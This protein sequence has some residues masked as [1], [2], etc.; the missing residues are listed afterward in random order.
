MDF[1]NLRIKDINCALKYIPQTKE[2]TS[3]NRQTHIIGLQCT[4]KFY[5]NFGYKDFF[6]EPNVI[7]FFNQRDDYYC[8]TYEIGESH[9]I[10]FTTY[11]PVET[12]S[13]CL[14]VKDS[15]EYLKLISRIERL[16][17]LRSSENLSLMS[18]MYKLCS[19]F[20]KI[21]N[22]KYSAADLRM[23]KAA[24]YIDEHFKEN[25]C[26][27]SAAALSG[28]SRRHFNDLFKAFYGITPNRRVINNKIEFSEMLLKTGSFSVSET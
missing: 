11:T 5:H 6:L 27:D 18:H 8:K 20:G 22:K 21:L 26:L 3:K 23:L 16:W 9:S 25:G 10:H 14:K 2:W 19:D 7:F 12:D 17:T 28:L 1:N 15:R 24:E 4:G 13:F